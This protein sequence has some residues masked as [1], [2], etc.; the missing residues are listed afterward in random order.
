MYRELRA[1]SFMTT[2]ARLLDRRRFELVCD[3]ADALDVLRALDGYRNADGGYGSGLEPDLRSPESQPAGALHALEVFAEVC[4][5]TT[6]RAAEVC[7]W[8]ASTT[9]D[10]GGLPFALPVT[11]PAGS[12]SF[13]V[14]AD[15]T[16][17]SL[18]ITAAV[19]SM[20]HRVARY[21]AAVRDH[22][23]L[24]RATRFCLEAIGR[25]S[26]TPHAIELMYVL[27]FLDVLTDTLPETTNTLHRVATYLPRNGSMRVAGGLDNELLHP[28]DF[29]PLPDRPLRAILGA[30][31]INADLKRWQDA[32]QPDGGWLVDFASASPIAALEWRGYATVRAATLLHNNAT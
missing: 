23:W 30:D 10:D 26:S 4:P 19:C 28:L 31:A 2:H 27:H 15:Q 7:N 24:E 25:I 11:D 8:L 22:P 3:K 5:L 29:S 32:Q 16:T 20:A 13:W 14:D 6:A 1:A 12:A 21:D 18:H 17:S 9:R